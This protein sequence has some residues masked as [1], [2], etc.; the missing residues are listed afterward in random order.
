[1]SPLTVKP[2]SIANYTFLACDTIHIVE[3]IFLI[4][5]SMKLAK[6]NDCRFEP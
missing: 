3:P 6:F 2:F 4:I 1:M 5:P